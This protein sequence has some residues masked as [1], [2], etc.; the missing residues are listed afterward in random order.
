[1]NPVAVA[2]VI[3]IPLASPWTVGDASTA[4]PPVS[5]TGAPPVKNVPA[6]AIAPLVHAAVTLVATEP[7]VIPVTVALDLEPL[8]QSIPN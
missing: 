3:K 4:V 5:A 8:E 1:M 2:S 7:V 6:G